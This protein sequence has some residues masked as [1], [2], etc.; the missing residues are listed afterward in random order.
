MDLIRASNTGSLVP[1]LEWRIEDAGPDQGSVTGR[2]TKECVSVF[3]KLMRRLPKENITKGT[4][5][6]L[7]RSCSS[8]ILWDYGYGVAKGE[9]DDVLRK[10]R[11][12]SRSTLALLVSIS[13]ALTN[14]SSTVLQSPYSRGN[15]TKPR[16]T[17]TYRPQ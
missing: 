1:V 12:L 14:R 8:L 13:G 10:S 17:V 6:S 16:P 11:T 2:L 15:L 9:L 3:R 5:R 7:E 4:F